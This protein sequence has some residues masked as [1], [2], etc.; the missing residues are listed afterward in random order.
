MM[1]KCQKNQFTGTATQP[2]RNRNATANYV[3]SIRT[4]TVHVVTLFRDSMKSSAVNLKMEHRLYLPGL[5]DVGSI[6]LS[7]YVNETS[8]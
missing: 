8:Q 6:A 1:K 7:N 3:N 2:Q 4:S 5:G